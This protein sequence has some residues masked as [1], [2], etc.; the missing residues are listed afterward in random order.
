MEDS[1]SSDEYEMLAPFLD[2]YLNVP[3]SGAFTTYDLAALPQNYRD[4]CSLTKE[5]T[6]EMRSQKSE[7]DRSIEIIGML[8]Q[9]VQDLWDIKKQHDETKV[10]AAF[11]E[12]DEDGS[13]EIDA[14]E[15]CAVSA[16]LG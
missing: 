10:L 1:L 7:P 11:R 15:L 16:N 2:Y 9:F 14:G 12:F 4:K 6:E 5:I 8:E 13:G 3:V